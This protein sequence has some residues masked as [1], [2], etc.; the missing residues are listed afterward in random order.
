MDQLLRQAVALNLDPMVALQMATC[1]PS[2]R[3]GLRDRGAIVPGRR[4]DFVA[5]T[6]LKQ[7]QGILTFKGG[8]VVAREGKSYPLY[9]PRFPAKALQTVKMK[10][11]EE[12]SLSLFLKTEKAWVIGIIPDQILTEKLC[13]P[14]KKDYRSMFISDIE[15]DILKIAVIERHKA[16]GNIG[17][18]LVKGL[19]LKRGALATSVAHDSHNIVVVGVSDEDMRQAIAAIQKLQG[20]LVVVDQGEVKASLPLPLAGLISLEAAEG[21]VSQMGKLLEAAKEIGAVSKNSFQTLSF[22][23]LPVIPELK[24]TD[25]GL[26]DVAQFRIIP[27]EVP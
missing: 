7:F 19:G 12:S 9:S 5:V 27:L 18:G 3:F 10:P 25:R 15:S 17:I 20:G 13:L 6:D 11:L 4:A 16:S 24:L 8:K 14:I 2:E 23:T 26:V 22:L 21:V 1:Y